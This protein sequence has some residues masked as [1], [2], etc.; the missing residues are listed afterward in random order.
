MLFDFDRGGAST[1]SVHLSGLQGRS[2]RSQERGGW[3]KVYP[4]DQRICGDTP[5]PALPREEWEREPTSVAATTQSDLTTRQQ[6]KRGRIVT[7]MP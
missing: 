2:T 1:G 3:G 4:L 5:T 6:Q 7:L